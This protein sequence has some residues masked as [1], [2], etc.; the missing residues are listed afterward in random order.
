MLRLWNHL[1]RNYCNRC[2]KSRMGLCSICKNNMA[3]FSCGRQV[4]I[5]NFYNTTPKGGRFHYCS[6]CKQLMLYY[7]ELDKHSCCKH[8]PD[9]CLN[10]SIHFLNYVCCNL[11][12][13]SFVCKQLML[14][15][16]ELD[17]HSSCKHTSETCL[18]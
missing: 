15:Y 17:K 11:L 12:D 7:D 9:T 4:I 13:Y 18:H 16:A 8:T 5:H 1:S 3:Q 6:I 14:Y 2:N 10:Y